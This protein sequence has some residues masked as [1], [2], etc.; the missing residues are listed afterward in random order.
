MLAVC[1]III[2]CLH[3]YHWH[4]IEQCWLF[5]ELFA[6]YMFEVLTISLTVVLDCQTNRL[7]FKQ[8]VWD[9]PFGALTLLVGRQEGHPACKKDGLWFVGDEDL[10]GAGALHV[11]QLQLSPPPP[12]TVAPIIKNLERILLVLANPGSS[13]KMAIKMERELDSCLRRVS[14]TL[15]Q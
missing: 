14:M 12:S 2:S 15:W 7:Y 1:L 11:L 5:C 4:D 9:F 13:G 8:I 3:W 10:P 6:C